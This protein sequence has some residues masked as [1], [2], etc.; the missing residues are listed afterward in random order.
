[1]MIE[2]DGQAVR[3]AKEALGPRPGKL[4]KLSAGMFIAYSMAVTR[5][6]KVCA[7]GKVLSVSKREA[8]VTVH[9]YGPVSDGHLRL[10]W[11][12]LFWEGGVLA[13]GSGATCQQW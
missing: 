13:F 6:R 8:N 3:S 4:E 1:M 11:K 9:Q 2:D 12:P 10:H 5:T 7:V